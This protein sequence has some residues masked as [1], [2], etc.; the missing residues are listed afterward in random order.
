MTGNSIEK[1]IKEMVNNEIQKQINNRNL[2][3]KSKAIEIAQEV[4]TDSIFTINEQARNF[5]NQ[6]ANPDTPFRMLLKELGRHEKT[7][8]KKKNKWTV[9]EEKILKNNFNKFLSDRA[10]QLERSNASIKAKLFRLLQQSYGA[11]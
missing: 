2:I 1:W 9:D 8:R 7:N 5:T 4:A 10:C 11:I 3:S 6:Q